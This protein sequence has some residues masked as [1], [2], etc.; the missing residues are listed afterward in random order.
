[1]TG[2]AGACSPLRL[3]YLWTL[4]SFRGIQL[5]AKELCSI[6][7]QVHD[8][9]PCNLLVFGVGNDSRLWIR[10]NRGGRTAFIEDSEE[11]LERARSRDHG[12]EA[13]LVA[14]GTRRTQWKKLLKTEERLSLRLP[15][16]IAGTR[17]DVVL[18]DAPA[19]WRDDLPGRMKSIYAASRLARKGGHVFVHDCGRIVERE[20]AD[21]FLRPE[22]LAEEIGRLR[23]YIMA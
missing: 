22:N 21:R 4:R 10:A 6:L 16:S 8:S 14:Y 11:W 17:W 9:A 2:T 12:I 13:C 19:G 1:M 20:Y 18:I 15:K 7:R 3:I 5:H 23:H